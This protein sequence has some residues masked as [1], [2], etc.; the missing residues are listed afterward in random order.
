MADK[1]P[2]TWILAALLLFNAVGVVL[3]LVELKDS[4]EKLAISAI[5]MPPTENET[6]DVIQIEPETIRYNATQSDMET[7]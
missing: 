1:R 2:L 5:V 4:D 7:E 3:I 6:L